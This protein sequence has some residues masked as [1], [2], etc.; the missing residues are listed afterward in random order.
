[1][2]R[3]IYLVTTTSRCMY[4]YR[5]GSWIWFRFRI[6][7]CILVLA[8]G[9]ENVIVI[10]I[11][12]EMRTWCRTVFLVGLTLGWGGIIWDYIVYRE[13]APRLDGDE[14]V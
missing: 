1:M 4:V 12:I 5:P 6:W 9:N 14:F 11:V 10:V 8:K 3:C 13:H 2:E 7:I